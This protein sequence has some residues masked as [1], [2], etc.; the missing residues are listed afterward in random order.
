M[1]CLADRR[2]GAS[3][4]IALHASTLAPAAVRM[5]MVEGQRGMKLADPPSSAAPLAAGRNARR[6]DV[7]A[8][9]F[10]HF[11]IV[12][13]LALRARHLRGVAVSVGRGAVGMFFADPLGVAAMAAG[14]IAH[15]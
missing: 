11:R 5:E 6:V 12:C 10:W 4:L 3:R 14:P 8:P 13:V 1:I 7:A 15:G 9:A 2:A